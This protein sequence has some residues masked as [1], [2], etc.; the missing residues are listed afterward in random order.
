[1]SVC[2]CQDWAL[3]VLHA[4]II[5]AITLMGPQWWLKAAIEQVGLMLSHHLTTL[6]GQNLTRLWRLPPGPACRCML[7]ASGT[8][9]SVWSC[10][11]WLL[12]WSASC[13]W[14]SASPTPSPRASRRCWVREGSTAEGGAPQ[15]GAPAPHPDDPSSFP[16]VQPEMQTLVERRIYP[17]LLML[18][19]LLVVLTFQIRQFR[20]LYEHIKNDKS[21]SLSHT[22]TH[23]QQADG[24]SFPLSAGS[25][26][27]LG[28]VCGTAAVDCC[29]SSVLLP[30]VERW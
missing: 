8:W 5:A 4:K 19:T 28:W 7:M 25:C 29:R 26:L 22:H 18:L 14:P 23:T 9:T 11:A 15:L 17:F 21:V 3:G 12:Q 2:V 20:R 16:G 1:M 27:T 24:C 13:C 30:P 10:M 6:L